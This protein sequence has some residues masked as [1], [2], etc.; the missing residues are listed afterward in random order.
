MLKQDLKEV[1]GFY[2]SEHRLDVEA[3]KNAVNSYFGRFGKSGGPT[4]KKYRC[5]FIYTCKL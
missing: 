2:G 4:I 5:S 1:G 3:I